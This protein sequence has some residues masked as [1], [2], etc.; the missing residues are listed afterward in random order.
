MILCLDALWQFTVPLFLGMARSIG[1]IPSSA[2]SS[3]LGLLFPRLPTGP[4]TDACFVRTPSVVRTSQV[5]SQRRTFN[6]FRSIIPRT[7]SQT[8]LSSNSPSPPPAVDLMADVSSRQRSPS[9]IDSGIA[10]IEPVAVNEHPEPLLQ[11]LNKIGASFPQH[12]ISGS[13]NCVLEFS[14]TQLDELLTMVSRQDEL[15]SSVNV[16][17]WQ[18]QTF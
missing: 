14:S 4:L 13:D 7:M 5:I 10:V 6:T 8:I 17:R 9:P 16:Y 2:N 3:L 1:R 15:C 12:V 18:F 11:Y